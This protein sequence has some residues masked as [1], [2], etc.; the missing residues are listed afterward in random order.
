MDKLKKLLYAHLN[1]MK[2]LGD[3][4]LYTYVLMMAVAI[5]SLSVHVVFSVFFAAAGCLPLALSHVAGILV[6]V[7]CCMCLVRGYFDL[8]GMALCIMILFSSLATIN[9]IGGDNFS[10]F[11]QLLVLLIL[12]VV[13]FENRKLPVVFTC[14][15]PFIMVGSYL[16][17]MNST[18]PY[19]IGIYNNVLSISNII[20]TFSGVV[21]LFSLNRM[22]RSFVDSF[23][24]NRM[25][26]LES[27]A[28]IDPLTKLYNRRYADIYFDQMC[29]DTGRAT[30]V[31]I[32][33]I[34][35]FK[36]VNDTWGHETG[37]VVLKMMSDILVGNTRKSDIVI[38]WGGE[39]FLVII[40]GTELPG[41]RI[42][43]EKIRKIIEST[44]FPCEES[45]FYLTITVGVDAFDPQDIVRSIELCDQKLYA[46]KRSGKNQVV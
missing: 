10:I 37:D 6:F 34:D 9:C 39:E 25:V 32:L 22:V 8:A 46:G 41:A 21:I 35:D 43:M 15:M 18:P 2:H 14:I 13:P 45:S 26:E 33:D 23:I 12:M 16:Y 29:D 40:T 42:M 7:L 44:A 28:Y 19:D 27:Q 17:D 20:V 36:N 24:Q 30:C 11:Y 5:V 4:A 38:R 1:K 31:A 3:E